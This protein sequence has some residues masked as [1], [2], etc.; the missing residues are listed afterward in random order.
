MPHKPTSPK[1][2]GAASRPAPRPTIKLSFFDAL[3]DSGYVR[4]S[5]LVQ[6]PKR[7]DTCS[8]TSPEITQLHAGLRGILARR[9]PQ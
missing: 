2:P 7:P 3:P 5:Q 8:S 6:S 4:E 9:A 1:A